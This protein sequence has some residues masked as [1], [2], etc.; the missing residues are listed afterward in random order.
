MANM[1]NTKT[2]LTN[3]H[4]QLRNLWMNKLR[5][6]KNAKNK[7]LTVDI[8]LVLIMEYI[9]KGILIIMI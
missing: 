9:N 4:R 8:P 2:I 7:A 6:F 5:T 1:V 3:K